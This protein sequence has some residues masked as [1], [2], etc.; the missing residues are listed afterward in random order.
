MAWSM[1]KENFGLESV[2]AG[3]ADPGYHL[4]EEKKRSRPWKYNTHP[5]RRILDG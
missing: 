4:K 5:G 3:D 1:T 2:I